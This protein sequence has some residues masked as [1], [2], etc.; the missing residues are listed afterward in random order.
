MCAPRG[1]SYKFRP[2]AEGNFPGRKKPEKI[3]LF[4]EGEELV[5]NRR[6]VRMPQAKLVRRVLDGGRARVRVGIAL[7]N[8]VES[9]RVKIGG[10]TAL[11]KMPDSPKLNRETEAISTQGE[12][13]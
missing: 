1:I 7:I 11:S 13:T 4:Y 8:P 12:P 2:Y 10:K 9:A 3:I 5:T 6:T